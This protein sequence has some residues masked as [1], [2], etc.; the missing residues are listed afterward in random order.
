MLLRKMWGDFSLPHLRYRL[1][2]P[3]I[4]ILFWESQRDMNDYYGKR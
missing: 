1:K 2:S 4:F 3:H